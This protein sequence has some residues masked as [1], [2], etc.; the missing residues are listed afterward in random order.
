MLGLKDMFQR[1]LKH[2]TRY[3]KTNN[4]FM[5][6]K[7][8]LFVFLFFFGISYGVSLK[9]VIYA[10]ENGDLETAYG[11]ARKL[12]SKERL[13]LEII[14]YLMEGEKKKAKKLLNYLQRLKKTKKKYLF[15][16]IYREDRKK[17]L[18]VSK[19]KQEIVLVEFFNKHPIIARRYQMTSGEKAGNKWEKGD[20]KTPDGVYFPLYYKTGLPKVYGSG[21]FPL[22]YPNVLDRYFFKKTGGGIW[23]HSS[24]RYSY[25]SKYSSKGCVIMKE[26]DFLILKK[27]IKIKDT[28]VVI[29]E[30]YEFID[31]ESFD[32]YQKR[33]LNFFMEW[34]KGFKSAINGNPIK[35][36]FLYSPKFV[37]KV[38]NKFK[39]IKEKYEKLKND[40]NKKYMFTNLSI[41][42]YG[43]IM[44]F[45]DI[46]VIAFNFEYFS[47]KRKIRE[48]KILYVKEEDGKFRIIG[49]E[50][51]PLSNF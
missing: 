37:S 15:N 18:V 5:N 25:I 14:L 32:K 26:P 19:A 10:I 13:K 11:L 38:G 45:G 46:F 42:K 6:F 31:R 50:N 47:D 27:Y 24:D 3:W 34:K 41:L 36:Y 43:R 8:F 28:P 4:R 12:D 29:T 49:E 35:M 40:K 51:I 17:V 22:N 44:L 48:K 23:L 33:L 30:D 2:L 7:I 9:S 1:L 39:Y 16:T 20:K 21:A